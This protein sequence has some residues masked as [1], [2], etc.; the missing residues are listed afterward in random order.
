MKNNKHKVI[1]IVRRLFIAMVAFFP[2]LSACTNSAGLPKPPLNLPFNVQKSGSKVETEL[3]VARHRV[4]SF[5]L[6]FMAKQ[7]DQGDRV[8]IGELAGR[9]ATDQNRQPI[10]VEP[11]VPVLLKLRIDLIKSSGINTILEKEFSDIRTAGGNADFVYKKITLVPL[12]PGHYRISIESLKDAP[13]LQETPVI[14]QISS[15][16]KTS[17][18]S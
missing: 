12:K 14:F 13:K 4:Y 2:W 9:W 3:W 7:N 16:P 8:R 1:M 15:D 18:L 6:M 10:E 17:D 5:N 11:G